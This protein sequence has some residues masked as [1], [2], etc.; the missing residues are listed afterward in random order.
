MDSLVGRTAIVCGS[1]QGIGKACAEALARCGATVVL[2]ARNPAALERVC[3]TLDRGASQSHGY[4]CA[5]FRDP[6]RVR[7][8]VAERVRSHGPVDIL[9]N[10]TGGPHGG[11]ILDAT[12]QEFINALTMHVVCFHVLAQIVVPGMKQRGFGRVINIAS[13]SVRQP[14]PNLGV[15]NTTRAAVA[16]WS[17]TLA[18][19]LAPHGITVNSLLPGF[20]DTARLHE[21]IEAR[22]QRLGLDIAEATRRAEAEAP[23][24]RFA[25]PE[26]IAAAVAFLASPQAGYITGICLPVDGGRITAI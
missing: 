4:L 1:T 9:V 7:A 8:I 20:T 22:A 6:D 17:K 18:A 26:E 12:P 3:G 25:R 11:P 10:N 24:G 19:E 23:I 5:D 13:T 21:V 14:I 16:A 2:L 15:S